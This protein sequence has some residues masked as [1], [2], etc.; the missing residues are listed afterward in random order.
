MKELISSNDVVFLSYTQ[1]LLYQEGIEFTLLDQNMSLMEGSV[2]ILPRRIMV[3][4]D[5]FDQADT[6]LK[7][8][9][10]EIGSSKGDNLDGSHDTSLLNEDDVTDDEF[11]GGTLKIYQSK[12][13]FRSGI[14]AVLLAASVPTHETVRILEAGSGAG[15]V[16]LA[17]AKRNEAAVIEGIEIEQVNVDLARKNILRNELQD[18]VQIH[19]GDLCDPIT[20]LEIL[21]LKRNSYDFV[22]AN[23]PF[24][25][26]GETRVSNNPL[27]LRARRALVDD[28]ENWVRFMTAMAAP[29]GVFSMIHRAERLDDLF[30]LLNGRFGG[31]RVLPIYSKEDCA[32]NRVLIQGVKGSRAPL[33]LLPGLVLHDETGGYVPEVKALCEGLSAVEGPLAGLFS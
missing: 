22:I 7:T 24:Y 19:L 33:K 28:L 3:S 1:D 8:S 9:L 12:S 31:L 17:V 20:K 13:G 21:G 30:K 2:G 10:A 4:E 15:V 16:S 11:L 26:E 25:N 29:K 23:P 18:R 27:R 14:D 6:L 5:C 32:A